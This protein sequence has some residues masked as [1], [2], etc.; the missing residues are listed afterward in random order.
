MQY[1]NEKMLKHLKPFAQFDQNAVLVDGKYDLSIFHL[2]VFGT[3]I[4]R[5]KWD[6][7]A[8]DMHWNPASFTDRDG[9]LME[10]W[11]H[12]RLSKTGPQK[13]IDWV[14]KFL[15]PM[16]DPMFMILFVLKELNMICSYFY[17]SENPWL[18]FIEVVSPRLILSLN[19]Y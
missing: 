5:I 17:E 12:G 19:D 18:Y 8:L 7:N 15:K 14:R 3:G 4:S 10:I 9:R 13:F 6:S 2:K 16:G 11:I 1:S